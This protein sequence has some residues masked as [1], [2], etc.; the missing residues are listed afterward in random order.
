MIG[1]LPMALP[2][3]L[4]SI[5]HQRKRLFRTRIL[6]PRRGDAEANAK[7]GGISRKKTS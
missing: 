7:N 4:T 2:Q 6:A 5:K 3:I 1:F